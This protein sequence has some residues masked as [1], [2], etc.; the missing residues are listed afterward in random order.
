VGGKVLL[1]VLLW[2]GLALETVPF[3]IALVL[4]LLA[5]QYLMLEIVGAAIYAR[6][7]NTAAI[8]VVDAVVIGW[9]AVTLTPIG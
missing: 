2:I 8:A 5:L 4:P 7:R 6:S 3:V 9:M 1:F